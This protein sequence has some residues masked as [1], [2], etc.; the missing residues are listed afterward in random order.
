M[1][2]RKDRSKIEKAKAQLPLPDL[3]RVFGLN[4]PPAGEGNMPSPFTSGRRQKSPSFSI[5]QRNG[6]WG[7][8]DRTGG[9]EI[10]GDEIILLEKLENLSRA[11][12]IARYVALAG[13]ENADGPCGSQQRLSSL[14]RKSRPLL[15][16]T[17][18]WPGA[19]A[20]FTAYHA[21]R[22]SKW[23]GYSPEFVEWIR[24]QELV[25]LY[26]GNVALPVHNDAGQ[27]VA[28]H[29]RS[30]NG[31]WFYAPR[32]IGSHPL[33][34]G[35]LRTAT[36]TMVFES[37]WDAFAIM[38][39]CG[40]HQEEPNGWAVLITRGACNGRFAA[41]AAGQVYAWPQNDTN[42]DGKRAGEEWLHD[43]VTHAPAK[44]FRVAVPAQFKD[45]ND[46]VRAEA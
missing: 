25:G 27:V 36:S 4:P 21:G 42:K 43:V 14:K 11:G 8:C 15:G 16:I 41:R 6:A 35:D 20:K 13:I 22:L 37:Q 3:L 17:V 45:A 12:A 18:D 10:K 7:W 44:V 31:R 9:Q 24:H 19:V 46:W 2:A 39:Q 29:I 5:F 26:N 40:W 23:R 33:I 38:D 34:I 28:M 32:G 1:T 30:K